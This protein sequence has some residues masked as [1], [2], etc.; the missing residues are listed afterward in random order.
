MAQK[1]GIP[2]FS[3]VTHNELIK[4]KSSPNQCMIINLDRSEGPGTHWVCCF[5]NTNFPYNIYF[6]SFGVGPSDII[7]KY[8]KQ[9]KKQVKYNNSELQMM[10]SIM[11]GYYC[12]YV[13][14]KLAKGH[15]IYDI[16][17][18][19]QQSPEVFNEKLIR[20][21]GSSL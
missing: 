17:M 3:V 15:N 1:L 16:L 12:I 20:K 2:N 19:F 7:L 10:E 11:C 9:N 4:K 6:D 13:L 5:T 21:F 8:L 14:D 18:K